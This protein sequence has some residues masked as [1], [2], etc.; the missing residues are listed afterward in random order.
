MRNRML[1][2]VLSKKNKE[3]PKLL[4]IAVLFWSIGFALG[5]LYGT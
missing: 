3:F 2:Q 5:M 4:A 1:D